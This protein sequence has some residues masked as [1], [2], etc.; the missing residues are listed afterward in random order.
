M[1][2]SLCLVYK[3]GYS[4]LSP[5]GA[6]LFTILSNDLV[7]KTNCTLIKSTDVKLG[8]VAI[9]VGNGAKLKDLERQPHL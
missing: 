1:V 4:E 5:G 9:S 2:I 3:M 7:E 8:A 6:V